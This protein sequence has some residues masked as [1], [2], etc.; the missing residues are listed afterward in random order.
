M[1]E[2]ALAASII[3]VIDL[4]AKVASQCSKYYANV[5]NAG[6]DIERLQQEIE[7]L[8]ATLG[9]VKSLCD[10]PNAAKLQSS[11]DMRNGIKDCK[12]QLAQLEKKLEPR[13]YKLMSRFGMHALTW[14]FKSNEVEEIM[15]KLGKCKDS[16]SFSLQVDQAV[17]VL[18]IHQEIVFNRLR[19]AADAAFDSHAEEHNARCYQGTRVDLLQQINAW[20]SDP[21][22]ECIFWLNGMAGTGKS[23]I[24]RTVAQNF[25]NE[26]DLGAS[27]FFKRGEGDR[28][29]AE[30]FFATIATQLVQALP[31]LAPHVQD[32]VE[33]DPAISK[34]ALKKQFEMLVLQPLGKIRPDLQKSSTIV[35][36]VDALDECDQEND[37][38][39]IIRLLPQVQHIASIR[40]KFFLTSRPELPI[41]LGFKDISGRYKGLVL[42][43]I[44]KPIIE[45]DISAFLEYELTRIRDEYNKSVTPDRQLPAD[46]PGRSDVQNLVQM[47]IPLFIF[48]TTICRFVK[49]R[50]CGEPKEQLAKVLKYKTKSQESEL[51]ATYLPV[52]D[53][54]LVGLTKS[55]KDELVTKFKE[56]VGTILIL[57]SPLSTVSLAR[58]LDISKA[59]VDHTLDLLHSVLSIPSNP[60][61]PVRLLHLSFRDFLLDTEKCEKHLF[62]IDEEKAH[63][64]LAAQCLQRLF[65]GLKRDICNL[66][67]PEKLRSDVDRQ[68]IDANLPPDIQYACQ[69]WVYHL[70]EGS[71]IICDDDEVYKFLKCHFL[72][73]LEALSLIQRLSESIGMINDLIAMLKLYSAALIFAPKDSVV[74]NIFQTYIPNWISQQPEVESS[75]NATLQTLEG[76][77]DSVN[78]VAFS[79]N[80]ELLASASGDTVRIWNTATGTLQQTLEGH[81]DWVTSVAFSHDS[82]LLASASVDKTVR[83]W[84]TA[85]STLQQTLEGHSDWVTSVAFSHDSELLASA[86]VDKTVRI[87]NTATSTLQQTLEGH[88]D[89]VTSVAFS[90]DSELLA[91]A[92][93][94][95]VRI[96]NTATGTLQQTLEI[97]FSH[98]SEL[99]A[100]ASDYKTVQIWN[101][102]TGT[103]QQTLEGHS[104]RVSSVAFSH[105]SELLASA[106]DDGSVRIWNAA[107]GTLQQTLEGL[108]LVAFS[109]NSEL[110]ASASGDTVWIWNTATG[111]LQQTLEG[112]SDWVTSVAFS[113]DSE[114]LAS[115]SVDKTVRIWNTATSTLQQTLEGHSDWVT[116][117]AFSHNSELLAS[118]SEDETIRIWNTATT[119]T[120]QQTLE[121]HSDGVRL[122][123]FSH[124]SE[125]LA[126]VSQDETVRIWNTAT[127]TLQQTLEGHSGRV[128]SV[129]FSHDS[130]LLA[131]ASEDETVQIWNTATGT[132]QQTLEGRTGGMSYSDDSEL[133]VFSHDSE[134]LALAVDKTVRIWNT[135][136][137][138]QQTLEGHSGRVWSV[139]F[140]HDSELLASASKDKTVRIWNAA[141][142]TLQQNISVNGHISSLLFDIT[143]MVLITNIGRITLGKTE[144]ASLSESSQ[145]GGKSHLKGLA[146]RGSWVTW[147]AQNLLWLPPDYRDMCSDIS[148]SGSTLAVGCKSGKV[149]VIG[150]SLAVLQNLDGY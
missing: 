117:V 106:S 126:S 80:S 16:I 13:G 115:A 17:Q 30:L 91:S 128:W 59:R 41:R 24:S 58:L 25:A 73:W 98:N 27:F 18:S 112:H 143:D 43:E 114:L 84:N 113:H 7:R 61:T 54:L 75:W 21:S 116:S 74:R 83:I 29:R 47:A 70:K 77:G 90:H 42:H 32:A 122:V 97:A 31:C 124:N 62:W 141:T 40:L 100:S 125:L 110:L 69:Y 108:N 121:G 150:F 56:V 147:N 37:L 64:K 148:L 76:H 138:L 52:L 102:A 63:K 135:A 79:H 71:G 60:D 4:S 142:G 5:K 50:R 134:L 53:Q 119:D 28:G 46:W 85:T 149:F 78:S 23:T 14:P 144:L 95:T 123:A 39:V 36:V 105:D 131:S 49:D 127:S 20:A 140:S 44:A 104:D 2:F 145:E 66:Q 3:T 35:I 93:G 57:A 82:E 68:T 55:R 86:S 129:A 45:H 101:T 136:T 72:H 10:G 34:K 81:S 89:W 65:K 19:S 118:A 51:D 139:A 38:S 103:L 88:S 87:W 94:D 130:E 8:T 133:L 107:T 22:S 1:A 120:L 111:T 99:L 48:A 33:A 9:Q 15:N 146:I 67:V 6:D 12:N 109:H 96:W 26:G 132:L 92:S 137:T 11:Q